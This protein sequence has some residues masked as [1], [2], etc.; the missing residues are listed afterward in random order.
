MYGC[1]TWSMDKKDRFVLNIWETE[2]LR[3][4]HATITEKLR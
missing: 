4:A 3:K 1:E 2:N